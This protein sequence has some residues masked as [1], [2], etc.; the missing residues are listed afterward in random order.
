M[1][2]LEASS[3]LSQRC[4]FIETNATLPLLTKIRVEGPSVLL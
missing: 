3:N 1:S 4:A 2:C